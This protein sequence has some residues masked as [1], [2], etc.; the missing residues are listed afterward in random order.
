MDDSRPLYDKPLIIDFDEDSL[1]AS[2]R[3]HRGSSP[4][5]KC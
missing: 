4:G 3:C 1:Q 2:G 5:D